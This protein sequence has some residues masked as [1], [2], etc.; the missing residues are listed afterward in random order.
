MSTC[1][2]VNVYTCLCVCMSVCLRCACVPVPVYVL[3]WVSYVH[4][5]RFL[6]ICVCTHVCVGPPQRAGE[7]KKMLTDG[8]TLPF[9]SLIL[10][11]IGNPHAVKQKPITFYRQVA[12]ALYVPELASDP[13]KLVASG[14]YTYTHTRTHTISSVLRMNMKINVT[15]NLSMTTNNAGV[16]VYACVVCGVLIGGWVHI[17]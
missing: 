3:V 2:C 14:I 15:M 6:D 9:D 12:A 8:K 10:C 5:S 7:L 17:C 1:R 4:V 16:W 11:N 13:H